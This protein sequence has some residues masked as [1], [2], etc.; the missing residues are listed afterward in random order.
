MLVRLIF[1]QEVLGVL[2]SELLIFE[3]VLTLVTIN[4]GGL[5]ADVD[6]LGLLP[7]VLELIVRGKQRST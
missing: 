2:L 6:R 4:G 5:F 7:R 1:L 3:L